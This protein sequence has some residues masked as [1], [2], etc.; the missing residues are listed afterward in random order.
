MFTAV[1][2]E[3]DY[4]LVVDQP[5]LA[6]LRLVE[7]ELEDESLLEPTSELTLIAEFQHVGWLALETLAEPATMEPWDG[8][9]VDW[10]ADEIPW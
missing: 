7:S 3:Y 4:L 8:S 10:A 2:H 1:Y 6:D 9:Y 5:T